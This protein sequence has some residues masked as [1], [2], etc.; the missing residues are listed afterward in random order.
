M[1]A[2]DG[3]TRDRSTRATGGTTRPAARRAGPRR[4]SGPAPVTPVDGL[5]VGD[6]PLIARLTGVL[7]VLAGVAGVLGLFPTYLV[8]GGTAVSQSAER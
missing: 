3:S 2:R 6:P 8:V 7:L 4:P 1:G 5:V